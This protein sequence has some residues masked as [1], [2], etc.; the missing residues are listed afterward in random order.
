METEEG[1]TNKRTGNQPPPPLKS[2]PLV[3]IPKRSR[4]KVQWS[5]ESTNGVLSKRTKCSSGSSSSSLI[6]LHSKVAHLFA[7]DNLQKYQDK[8]LYK[9]VDPRYFIDSTAEVELK[10]KFLKPFADNNLLT[11]IGMKR[12][13]NPDLVKAFYCNLELTIVGLESRFKNNIFKFVYSN[14]TKYFDLTCEGNLSNTKKPEYDKALFVLAI[15]KYVCEHMEIS[16]FRISQIKFDMRLLRWIIV[17]ILARKLANS[18]RDDD[19]DLFLMWCVIQKT[20]NN[21]VKFI[22]DKMI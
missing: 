17:K 16:N 1:L 10:T 13:Y 20:K 6:L 21:R 9:P 22:I 11:F 18:S 19:N 15:S 14:F 12:K 4:K 7:E 3:P 5:K 8:L 2:E